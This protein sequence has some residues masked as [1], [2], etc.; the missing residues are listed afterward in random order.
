MNNLGQ[1]TTLKYKAI[2]LNLENFLFDLTSSGV[3]I[4]NVHKKGKT[5]T[6]EAHSQNDKAVK[7]FALR[8]GLS[9][10]VVATKG[11]GAWIKS[12][13]YKIG[14]ALGIVYTVFCMMYFTSFI[15]RVDYV[16]EDSHSCT[17]GAKCIFRE[18]NLNIIKAEL[19]KTIQVGEKLNTNISD[20]QNHITANFDLVE[21]C[22]IIKNGNHISVKL[23]E[24]V[25]K[26]IEKPKQIIAQQ[27]CIIKNIT[28]YS[29]KALVKAGDIVQKGQ[30]L[31]DSDG[32]VLPSASI[33]AK[34]WYIGTAIH[35]CNQSMLVETGNKFISSSIRVAN[36]DLIKNKLCNYQY[37]KEQIT[38]QNISSFLVPITKKTHIFYEMQIQ[39][40]YV[41]W[42]DVK[43]SVIAQSK[44]DAMLK[45]NGSPVDV[46]YSI[47][48][49]NDMYKVD[50]Y[51]LCEEQIA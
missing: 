7:E 46:T 23:Y 31:V 38:T 1:L 37:Y 22:S 3:Y 25:A 10:K 14:T 48:K 18:E 17:N 4:K 43:S 36:V 35:Q 45:T 6:F 5:L 33:I 19:E 12:L 49:Q 28:T 39:N 9:L 2:G 51:L 50:C 8:L 34:I 44:Q 42:E 27:N 41:P 15:S 11:L 40:V 29:G 24:A 16:L 20:I 47:V 26:D 13:P 30:V 21:N 32:S